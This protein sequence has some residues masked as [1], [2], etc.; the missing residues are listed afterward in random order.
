MLL[1]ILANLA[2]IYNLLFLPELLTLIPDASDFASSGRMSF[3]AGVYIETAPIKKNNN[4]LGMAIT[5]ESAIIIDAKSGLALWQKNPEAERPVA[6]ITKLLTALVFL[7]NNPGWET[8]VKIQ[9]SDYRS[10]G[11]SYLYDGEE[12][13]VKDIFYTALIASSN[14]ATAAL[15]RSTGLNE[16]EFVIKMNQKAQRLGLAKSQWVE[17]TGLNPKNVATAADLGR[18]IQAAFN[19]PQIVQ[20][21]QEE[22]YIFSVLNAERTYTVKNTDKLLKSYLNILAGKTGYLE[23]AGYCLVS[24]IYGPAEQEIYVVVLG[25]ESET[26]RFQEVKSLAQW[27]FDNYVWEEVE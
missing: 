26:S 12:I 19:Q 14:E 18:L 9:K 15:V 13:L 2:V 24:K 5:A 22:E 10:G 1:S 23:E 20:A 16:E 3:L 4:S 17:P 8:T 27:A 25:S 6:S 11:R 21:T 7:D